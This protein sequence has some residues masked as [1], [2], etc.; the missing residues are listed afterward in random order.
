MALIIGVE[1]KN[2]GLLLVVHPS[3]L[4]IV[5]YVVLW[6]KLVFLFHLNSL[7]QFFLFGGGGGSLSCLEFDFITN[8]D[9]FRVPLAV[10][11]ALNVI[12]KTSVLVCVNSRWTRYIK[13]NFFIVLFRFLGSVCEKRLLW[14]IFSF[15]FF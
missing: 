9:L 14:N 5:V 7:F 2:V 4:H 6:A 3:V 13:Q 8:N 10:I 1:I 11:F 12:N 15:L